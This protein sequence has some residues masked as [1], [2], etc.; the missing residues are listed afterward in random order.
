MALSTNTYT[1]AGGAQT[2]AVNFALGFI[3]RSDVK[4]RINLALDGS[5][6]PSY[7]AFTWIDD[8]NISVTPT[9]TIGD[10][11]QLERTVS[12]TELKVNFSATADITPAN[13]DLSAKHG[14]MVY[15]ELVDGRVDGAE[16]PATAADRAVAAAAAALVSEGLADADRVATNADVVLTAADVGS[17]NAD[18]VLTN[19]DAAATAADKVSTN[20]DVVLTTADVASAEADKVQ[21]GLDRIA[22]AADLVAT[23]Q[24]TIDTAADLVATAQDVIDSA[25]SEAAAAASA[26]AI[27]PYTDR[28]TAIAATVN[29]VVKRIAVLSPSG[30]ALSYIRDVTGTALTT[31]GGTIGWSP[32]GDV[33]PEHWG[34]YV[35]GP[36]SDGARLASVYAFA[37]DVPLVLSSGTYF[38]QSP[39]LVST[40]SV[41]RGAAAYGTILYIEDQDAIYSSTA[42]ITSYVDITGVRLKGNAKKSTSAT[43]TY[44]LNLGPARDCFIDIVSEGFVSGLNCDAKD[45]GF[46]DLKGKLHVLHTQWPNPVN[47]SPKYGIHFTGGTKKPQTCKLD[48][49][50]YSQL[51]AREFVPAGGVPA[52]KEYTFTIPLP[53]YKFT[54][55]TTRTARGILVWVTDAGGNKTRTT[56]FILQDM[57]SGSPVALASGW[58]NPWVPTATAN[59]GDNFPPDPVN[60]RVDFG[61][62]VAVGSTVEIFYNDPWGIIGI[63]VDKG[64]GNIFTGTVGGYDT[65]VFSNDANNSYALGYTQ[66]ALL[67]FD[68]NADNNT[69]HSMENNNSIGTKYNILAGTKHTA[70]TPHYGPILARQEVNTTTLA[71]S[72]SWQSL[73][74]TAVAQEP[75]ET[76]CLPRVDMQVVN[77]SIALDLEVRLQRVRNG[78]TATTVAFMKSTIPM[79]GASVVSFEGLDPEI[80]KKAHGLQDSH[81]Y[82]IQ[83]RMSTASGGIKIESAGT[84]F[85]GITVGRYPAYEP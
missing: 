76:R 43:T 21:T 16:S 13:L 58:V 75:H 80:L 2:F 55:T 54:N 51:T 42:S 72:T 56:D 71:S 41:I 7:A 40:Y 85:S 45:L 48:V 63:Y 26:A 38:L 4:V 79:N 50:P 57:T 27:E 82:T 83:V 17:T 9:L 30:P 35:S 52:S 37:K 19:A 31:N 61:T 12:K 81:S 23:N 3:Q 74:G 1:Y 28:A 34:Q 39:I 18:V 78:G 60:L 47:G 68:I 32:D 14:L 8:S 65:S 73:T 6:D 10:S 24:D 15:Q 44:G 70:V 64:T 20:A 25:A 46:I 5:G 36:I 66:T 69:A 77:T 53:L 49:K 62:S 22:V 33:T 29:A 84:Y 67:D 59:L 11:V